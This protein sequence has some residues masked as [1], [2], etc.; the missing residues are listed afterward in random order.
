MWK[1]A[2]LVLAASSFAVPALAA[3]C[4]TEIEAFERQHKLS[5]ALP[6]P[7]A[8]A[9]SADTPATT[10]SRGVP[11]EDKLGPSGGVL[12]PPEGGRSAVIEPPRTGPGSEM[13]PP[14]VPPH[15]A[16]GPSG[17]DAAELNAAKRAQIQAH[18]NAA[19]EADSRGDEKACFERLG[20]A[21]AAL[22]AR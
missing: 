21:R 14:A 19:H 17:T 4:A 11:P 16:E 2:L 15:T 1:A 10:E 8:P 9:G 18:L 20:D 13:T 6:R 22:Q 7:D 5:A 3:S 12:A